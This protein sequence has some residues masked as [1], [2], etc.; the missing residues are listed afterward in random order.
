MFV[1]CYACCTCLKERR[2]CM[3]I[4]H[5]FAGEGRTRNY[6]SAGV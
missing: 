1:E 2:L 6:G 4:L 3:C 5:D